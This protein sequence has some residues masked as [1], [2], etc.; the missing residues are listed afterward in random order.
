MVI[1]IIG[2]NGNL[3]SALCDYLTQL[4]VSIC[5]VTREHGPDSISFAEFLELSKTISE[6]HQICHLAGKTAADKTH[7]V[8]EL[9]SANLMITREMIENFKH[10]PNIDI[11]SLS[12][13]TSEYP[14]MLSDKYNYQISKYLEQSL[15]LESHLSTTNRWQLIRTPLVIGGNLDSQLLNAIAMNIDSNLR[16]SIKNP[17]KSIEFIDRDSLIYFIAE[18]MLQSQSNNRLT[19][20]QVPSWKCTIEEFISLIEDIF[21][22]DGSY[23]LKK[24][25]E[26]KNAREI[27]EPNQGSKLEENFLRLKNSIVENINLLKSL[28]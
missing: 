21:E 24:Y 4:N 26:W 13:V 22:S 27:E 18:V 11:V 28:A 12:S 7:S 6:P 9:V 20:H 23:A 8:S 25:V 17:T 2:S 15:I 5:K 19:L 14:D 1:S 3:G 16:S 10:L